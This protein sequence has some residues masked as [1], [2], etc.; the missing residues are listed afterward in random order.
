MSEEASNSSLKL[1]VNDLIAMKQ[2]IDVAS[3]RGMFKP[4]EMALVGQTYSKLTAFI[5]NINKQLQGESN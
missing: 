5:E 4:E 3:Q 1:G 2:I